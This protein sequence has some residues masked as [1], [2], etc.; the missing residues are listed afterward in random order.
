[1]RTTGTLFYCEHCDQL[2][3]HA[4]W[5]YPTPARGNNCSDCGAKLVVTSFGRDRDG[6]VS[7]RYPEED[8]Q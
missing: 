1:M 7:R 3:S 5:Q 2:Y 8:S 6:N 4:D